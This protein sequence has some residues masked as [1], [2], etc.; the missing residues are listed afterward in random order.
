[1]ENS[2]LSFGPWLKRLRRSRDLTQEELADRAGC[3]PVTLHKI[4]TED[5]RPSKEIAQR[6]AEALCVPE[7]DQAAFIAFARASYPEKFPPPPVAIQPTVPIHQ[8][9]PSADR[10]LRSHNLPAQLTS[11][12]G[13][14]REMPEIASLLATTRL[15]TLTGAGGSGKTRLGLEVAG[16]LTEDFR[17][18]VWLADLARLADPNLVPQAIAAA[19]GVR[20]EGLR[21]LLDQLSDY[22]EPREMLLLLDNCE[23]LIDACAAVAHRLL[24]AAPDLKILA[25]SRE[26]LGIGGELTFVVPT[27]AVPN[28]GTLPPLDA[29]MRFGAIRLFTER[30]WIARPNFTLSEVNG[31]AVA[32]IC[33]RL[34]GM[35]LA[36]ELAASRVRLLPVEEIRTRLADRFELLT[37]GSRIAL[38]RHQTLRA[39]IEWSYALLT[40]P[41]RGLLRRLAVFAGGWTLRAAEVVCDVRDDAA[42]PHVL[43]LMARLVDKSLVVPEWRGRTGR[44]G[45]LET[46]RQ[47]A[48]EQL[49]QCGEA[50]DV[51]QRHAAYFVALAEEAEDALM[52]AEQRAWQA[53]LDDEHNNIQVTF[54]WLASAE[55]HFVQA[56]PE[57]AALR[58]AGALWRYWEVRGHVAEGREQ[59]L[60]RLAA[61]DPET[62]AIV[63]ARGH[64]GAG[65]CTWYQGDFETATAHYETSV[66]L[67]RSLGDRRGV[68]RPLTYLAWLDTYRGEFARARALAEEAVGICREVGDRQ[69]ETWATARLGIVAHW[70]GDPAKAAPL[71]ERALETSREMGDD[72]GTGWWLLMLGQ[73]LI[74]LNQLDRAMALEVECAQCTRDLG[75]R[76]D[77]AFALQS[78]AAILHLQG[79]TG[80]ALGLLQETARILAELGDLF[81][82]ATT[83]FS[84]IIPLVRLEPILCIR[85]AAAY[86]AVCKVGGFTIPL[87]WAARLEQGLT[88]LRAALGADVFDAA[89]EQGRGLPVQQALAEAQAAADRLMD[90]AQLS[91]D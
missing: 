62:P 32:E 45:M 61:A 71:L 55:A 6:L 65:I 17:D 23:H 59:L 31:A 64:L 30:A 22:C 3:A 14:E 90:A 60:P 5:R 20:D 37:G 52:G 68:A 47:F 4:E 43:D 85:L 77:Y 79:F 26:P 13:H 28:P 41:E 51:R 81:G 33:R 75:D 50:A 91:A 49:E 56:R 89:W 40:E 66:A 15:L 21:P 36:I 87:I 57:E 38:P 35:P 80:Q 8:G 84:Y 63:R 54:D 70:A 48:L 29:L 69:G 73:V 82:L 10:P 34:D 46:L 88:E 16:R 18:G 44:Y 39:T 2:E 86:Q 67:Y 83:L 7:S 1:M 24:S 74:T 11:F 76:R 72:L 19:L 25:T 42:Q 12:V 78:Q 27:L 9:G 53:R 58:M